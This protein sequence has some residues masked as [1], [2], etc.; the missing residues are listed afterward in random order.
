MAFNDKLNYLVLQEKKTR[1]SFLWFTAL[2]G[3]RVGPVIMLGWCDGPWQTG[4]RV[5]DGYRRNYARW[6]KPNSEIAEVHSFSHRSRFTVLALVLNGNL[7]SW[8]LQLFFRS[9]RV[10]CRKNKQYINVMK[11]LN[12]DFN[13]AKCRDFIVSH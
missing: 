1:R 13:E 6:Q 5:R 2:V 11:D 3:H 12:L 8:K 9:L 7:H 10:C 4:T